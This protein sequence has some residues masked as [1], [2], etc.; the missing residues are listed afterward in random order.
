MGAKRKSGGSATPPPKSIK[1]DDGAAAPSVPETSAAHVAVFQKWL[2]FD[3]SYSNQ[4]VEHYCF[5]L[6][7]KQFS[8]SRTAKLETYSTIE[9]VFGKQFSEKAVVLTF[10]SQSITFPIAR[11][12]LW[13]LSSSSLTMNFQ[14]SMVCVQLS[15]RPG[16]CAIFLQSVFRFEAIRNT[17]QLEEERWGFLAALAAALFTIMWT[18]GAV[19]ARH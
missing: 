19:G 17:R 5:L 12:P 18:K 15:F 10:F 1:G 16:G 9:N 2:I 7:V 6:N 11:S 8:A 4:H 3:C 13:C 14:Q